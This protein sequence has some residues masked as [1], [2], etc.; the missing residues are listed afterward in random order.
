MS[1]QYFIPSC[2][3]GIKTTIKFGFHA[4]FAIKSFSTQNTFKMESFCQS[5]CRNYSSSNAWKVQKLHATIIKRNTKF[6]WNVTTALHHT[7]VELNSS[8]IRIKKP[9]MTSLVPSINLLKQEFYSPVLLHG[10]FIKWVA[11]KRWIYEAPPLKSSL[12]SVQ[13]SIQTVITST[14]EWNVIINNSFV[15]KRRTRNNGNRKRLYKSCCWK[16]ASIIIKLR[17][18]L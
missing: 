11:F 5:H 14:H 8:K 3:C 16:C 12:I 13:Y 4:K 18:T 7:T 15:S 6:N 10:T 17:L 2:C 9:Q 1:I